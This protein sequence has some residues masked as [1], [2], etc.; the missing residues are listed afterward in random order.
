MSRLTIQFASIAITVICLLAGTRASAQLA[1]DWHTV[2]GGGVTS[3]GESVGGNYAV[4]G[5]IG[6]PDAS[7]FSAPMTGSGF[8]I[9]GGFWV[10]AGASCQCPGDLNADGLIS[11]SDIQGFV[12]CIINGGI[13]GCADLDGSHVVTLDD[14]DA[15]VTDLIE[16]AE[17]P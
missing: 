3:P 7:S 6:Q 9:V 17:C 11:G 5:T 16:S 13:C 1:I 14:V 15:F 12:L 4:A 10:A 2:D 8:E